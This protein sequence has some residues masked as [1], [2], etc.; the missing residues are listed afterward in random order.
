MS[1]PVFTLPVLL[2]DPELPELP[3][4]P[5]VL[6]LL[7]VPVPEV[8]VVPTVD[9]STTVPNLLNEVTVTFITPSVTFPVRVSTFPSWV[10]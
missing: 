7:P 8:A 5:E 6:E 10:T 9:A 4:P 2:L 1:S 3:L